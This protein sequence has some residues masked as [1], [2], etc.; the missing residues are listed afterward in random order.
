MQL[1]GEAHQPLRDGLGYSAPQIADVF[2]EEQG[3]SERYRPEITAE[4]LRQTDAKIGKL[5]ST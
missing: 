2:T 5:L 3:R 1:I 4:V